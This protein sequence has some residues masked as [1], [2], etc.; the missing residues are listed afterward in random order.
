VLS[1]IGLIRGTSV[2]NEEVGAALHRLARYA[3]PARDLVDGGGL[4]LDRVE[5]D[6]AR[7][8]RCTGSL[9]RRAGRFRSRRRYFFSKNTSL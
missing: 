7:R 5:D 8:T 2:A 9:S 4:V 6:P 1:R 3:A